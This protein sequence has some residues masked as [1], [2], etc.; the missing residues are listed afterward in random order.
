[1]STMRYRSAER[2]NHSRSL[3]NACECYSEQA[4]KSFGT[5]KC[6]SKYRPKTSLEG[7]RKQ[8]IAV[9]AKKANF[10]G[11][12]PGRPQG[13]QGRLRGRSQMLQNAS[14]SLPR[15]VLQVEALK[16]QFLIDVLHGIHVFEGPRALLR[17]P[18]TIKNWSGTSTGESW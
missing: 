4:K 6:G 2:N 18:K 9:A 17:H 8:E 13:L 14:K 15:G 16:T 10:A 7:L 3:K 5:L 12:H 11:R 1:M